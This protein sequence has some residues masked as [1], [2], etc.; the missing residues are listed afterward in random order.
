MAMRKLIT[1]ILVL[2][3]LSIFSQ[4]GFYKGWG[5][6]GDAV[7]TSTAF[8]G[9][10]DNQPF[11][12]KVNNRRSGYIDTIGT[13]F[14]GFKSGWVTSASPQLYNSAFGCLT[15][16]SNTSGLNNNAFGFSTLYSNV[17]GF[18]NCGFGYEVLQFNTSG[19]NN[20]GFGEGALQ[21]N[22]GTGNCAFGSECLIQNTW[23]GGNTAMGYK[24]MQDG[25]H[26]SNNTAVGGGALLK[27]NG[28]ENVAVGNNALNIDSSGTKNVA[29][30][31][32]ALSGHYTG[33]F[34]TAIGY[35]SLL[36][37]TGSGI[38]G[39]GYGALQ[40]NTSGVDNTSIGYNSLRSNITGADNTGAG[41]N[42][43]QLSTGSNNTGFG[44]YTGFT[45]SSG[46]N[47]T[48]CG[49]FAGLSNATT[50][51]NVCLGH[52]AGRYNVSAG[53]FI[54][55]NTDRANAATEITNSILYGIMASTPTTQTLSINAETLIKGRLENTQGADVASVAGAIAVGKD[56]NVF[57]ITGTNAITL[58]TSTDWQN[59]AEITLIFTSTAS[60]TD[61]TANSGADIGFEL[62]GNANFNASADD[63][64]TLTLCEIGGTVR[65]REK[66]R[67]VN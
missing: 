13:A 43:F 8:I 7:G 53:R 33:S 52:S 42:S 48:Y 17:N 37:T 34:C 54:V 2:A 9:T 40:A 23:T 64:I 49:A 24:A 67:S 21:N 25:F 58:I 5:F 27:C 35:N 12:I 59:G 46:G 63:S 62:A 11:N 50:S 19:S 47:N 39:V 28:S 55:D 57:E 36:A 6:R 51:G 29:I 44:S 16:F 14:F 10:T 61:G 20:S 38:T 30:G 45:N 41:Y 15:L 56:G 32:N 3:S 4:N 31:N 60:L 65:W 66:C 18:N 22:N 1:L 26:P